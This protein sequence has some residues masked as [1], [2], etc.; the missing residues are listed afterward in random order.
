MTKLKS[1]SSSK[2]APNNALIE[3]I[4]E[5][6]AELRLLRKEVA[7][8]RNLSISSLMLASFSIKVS[9]DGT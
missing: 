1:S 7:E 6:S 2:T 8:W 3:K 9:V 4:E 5:Q